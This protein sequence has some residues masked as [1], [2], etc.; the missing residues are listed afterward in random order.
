MGPIIFVKIEKYTCQ[1]N[2]SIVNNCQRSIYLGGVWG[3]ELLILEFF[4]L[5]SKFDKLISLELFS[6]RLGC[7]VVKPEVLKSVFG[8]RSY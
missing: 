5:G 4:N 3:K 8:M 1:L 2:Q 7:R 6:L